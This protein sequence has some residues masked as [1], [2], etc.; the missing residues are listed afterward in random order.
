MEEDWWAEQ[1]AQLHLLANELAD[2]DEGFTEVAARYP[3]V[4][5]RI[6][7]QV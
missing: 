3:E 1:A 4:R 7:A 6:K 2:A 5:S